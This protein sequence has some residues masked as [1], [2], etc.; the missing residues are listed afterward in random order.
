MPAIILGYE[1]YKFIEELPADVSGKLGPRTAVIRLKPDNAE[2]VELDAEHITNMRTG[3]AGALGVKYFAPNSQNIAILGTGKIS[4]ALA[5]C[6][7]ELGTKKINVYSRNPENREGFKTELQQIGADIILH[8]SVKSCVA[9]SEAILTAVPTPEPILFLKDLPQR[10]YISVM[11]GD[12][13]TA[14][15]D[16]EIIE[17][18]VVVPDN[19][20]QCRKSGEFKLA[21]E[22][23]YY[24]KINFAQINGRVANIGDAANGKLKPDPGIIVGYFTGLAVQDIN[25][26]RMVYEKFIKVE[27]VSN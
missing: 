5:L 27:A 15:L 8:D 13:R 23:G 10:I 22:K 25:A 24:N 6:A 7:A 20:E 18:G 2:E 11:G 17:Q 4:K 16:S 14:Q 1:G 19:L 26:A 9:G 12:S 3:A 21:L